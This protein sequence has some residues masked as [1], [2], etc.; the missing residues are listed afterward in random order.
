MS[1]KIIK[2][3]VTTEKNTHVFYCDDCGKLLMESW[4]YDDGYYASPDE[5]TVCG[6][7][8]VG[9]YCKECGEKRVAEIK[10]KLDALFNPHKYEEE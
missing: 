8:I 1:K 9:D 6:R 10:S 5:F 3:Q 7:R 2:E 4:E